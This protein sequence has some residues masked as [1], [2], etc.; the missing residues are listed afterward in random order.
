MTTLEMKEQLTLLKRELTEE[1][2]S[3]GGWS[4]PSK[5]CL[6]ISEAIAHAVDVSVF[7]VSSHMLKL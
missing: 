5:V 6:V 1:P 2:R 7:R 3:G 4:R